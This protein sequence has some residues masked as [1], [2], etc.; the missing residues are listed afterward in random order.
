MRIRTLLNPFSCLQRYKRQDWLALFPNFQGILDVEIGFGTGHFIT[1]YAKTFPTHAVVGF[2]IRKKLVELVQEK[3]KL[4][5]LDNTCLVWGNGQYGLED[6]FEDKSIDRIFV[7]HP[8]PWIKRHQNKRRVVSPA[9]LE[10]VHTKLKP[11]C[12]LYVATDV[13]ELWEVMLQAIQDS[14][15]FTLIPDDPFWTTLYHTRWKEM[16]LEHN[17]SLFYGTFQAR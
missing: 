2:E 10:L 6:M 1:S 7:F 14:Q 13:P 3:S 12:H 5:Q 9:F 11:G 15:K 16:S 17:R 8:D 4:A